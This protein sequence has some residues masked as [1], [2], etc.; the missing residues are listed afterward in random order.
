MVCQ[1]WCRV[2]FGLFMLEWVLW[3][4]VLGV[5]ILMVKISV[6]Q[7]VVLVCFSVL[8]I[9]LWLCRI[10][11]WNYIGCLMVGVIFL[12]GQ[13]EMVERVNGMFLLFVVLV[14]CILLWWVYILYSL[15]GVNV[16]GIVSFLL[17][18]VVFRFRFD[19]LCK[20]CWCKVILERFLMLWCRVCLVQVLLLIQWNRNGGR[21]CCVVV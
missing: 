16:V 12:I 5:G 19:I 1:Q 11:S 10:Y 13:M 3:Q 6:E 4:W 7:L 14:V 9:K 21:I 8:C 15:I 17:N 20:I 18:N 2:V